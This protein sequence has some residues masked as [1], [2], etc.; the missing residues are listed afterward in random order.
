[1]LHCTAGSNRGIWIQN[2]GNTVL[3][4]TVVMTFDEFLTAENVDFAEPKLDAGAPLSLRSCH[5]PPWLA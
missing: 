2:T 3:N 5:E 1:M 4:G